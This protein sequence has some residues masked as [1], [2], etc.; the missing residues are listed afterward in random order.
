MKLAVIAAGT[1]GAVVLLSAVAGFFHESREKQ[2]SPSV[3][4]RAE[5]SKME[6]RSYSTLA[7][8]TGPMYHREADFSLSVK[9]CISVEEQLEARASRVGGI[10]LDLV[11]E[12]TDGAR[13]GTVAFKIP[14]DKVNEFIREV[15]ELGKIL[16]ERITARHVEASGGTGGGTEFSMV[17]VHIAD[18]AVAP[19]TKEGQGV[20]AASFDKSAAHFLRGL[21]VLVEV[22]GF[23]LPYLLAL[24]LIGVPVLVAYRMRRR[25]LA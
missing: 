1:L 19:N 15:R 11:L 21:A 16:N 6:L 25:V 9:D 4:P 17:R 7:V 22:A 10:L 18:E 12:G 13:R 8:P 3:P 20:F 24:A 14:S 23:V 5:A 2:M